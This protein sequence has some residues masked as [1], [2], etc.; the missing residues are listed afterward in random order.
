MRALI[1][2]FLTLLIVAFVFKVAIE[3]QG[4]QDSLDIPKSLLLDS[5][6]PDAGLPTSAFNVK[7]IISA[8]QQR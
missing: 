5:L 8:I 6:P 4:F 1:R 3:A 2:K 7:P